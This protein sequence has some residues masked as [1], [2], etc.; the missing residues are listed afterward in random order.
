MA[1]EV[2][3]RQVSKFRPFALTPMHRRYKSAP[4]QEASPQRAEDDH[5]RA[6]R[7]A[8][9]VIHKRILLR[10]FLGWLLLSTTIT[11]IVLFLEFSRVRT[12]V[13]SLALTESAT[14]SGESAHKLDR[15]D[16]EAYEHLM[17][18]AQQ[19]VDQHF[20]VVELYDR[21]KQLKLEAVRSGK[22]STEQAIHRYRHK[23]PRKGEFSHELHF[24]GGELV[25][26]T[27]VPLK[28]AP[29]N[30]VGY[31]EGIYQVDQATLT[32]IKQYLFR[33]LAFVTVS[34]TFTTALMYPII[35]T[36]HRGLIRL[37]ADLFKGNLELLDVLGCAIAERDSDT[38][39]HNYRVTFYTLRLGEALGLSRKEMR[40]LI[41][42]AFLHDVGKIGIRDPI[43]LKP[44]Q[45]TPEEFEVMKTHVRL[46]VDVLS[47]SS[48]LQG[49]QDVVEFHHERYDGSGYLR[50]LK[51][52]EIPLNA[53]IFAI[54]DVFDALTSKR[55]YKDP[56][57]VN[58]VIGVL[59]RDSGS[60]FDPHLVALFTNIAPRL[61]EEISRLDE[62]QME[63]KLQ[64][65]IARYFLAG[66]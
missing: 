40:D 29:G 35:L 12:F 14:F 46:G 1:R 2:Q 57:R 21:T 3:Q 54:V 6:T 66:S 61:H 7:A 32:G 48:W 49:A 17:R 10:L 4:S 56:W 33:T 19:L 37:S 26:V 38:N 44:G 43:L 55:P 5:S 65:L 42:G 58:E 27:L 30:L 39:V 28:D 9:A 45:L 13:H 64:P 20:L 36:L 63:A 51:G 60:R 62:R 59:E 25:L 47:K 16:A 34:I 15:I 8:S 23:F 50:G 52:E 41:A 11:G 22:E 31:F 18:L 53:R 24:V